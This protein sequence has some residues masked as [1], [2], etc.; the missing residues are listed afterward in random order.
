M[1]KLIIPMIIGKNRMRGKHEG[2]MFVFTDDLYRV[3]AL[4]KRIIPNMTPETLTKSVSCILEAY[5]KS[6]MQ[7]RQNR[8]KTETMGHVFELELYNKDKTVSARLIMSQ[9]GTINRFPE[10]I[11]KGLTEGF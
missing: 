2:A 5:Y 8:D 6:H 11:E 7:W 1:D 9:E 10:T 3:H 4:L